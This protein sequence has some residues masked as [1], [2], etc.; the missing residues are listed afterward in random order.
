MPAKCDSPIVFDP[1]MIV[2]LQWV[3]DG[4][5]SHSTPVKIE[6]SNQFVPMGSDPKE[7]K[8]V[9]KLM[10]EGRRLSGV[11][12]GPESKVLDGLYAPE[13]SGQI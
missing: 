9:Q 3:A 1:L 11:H 8:R 2:L 12:A 6:T 4:S 7:F 13:T 5:P 10:K